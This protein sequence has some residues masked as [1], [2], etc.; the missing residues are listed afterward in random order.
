MPESR[1]EAFNHKSPMG[2]RLMDKSPRWAY[3]MYMWMLTTLPS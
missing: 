2:L 3:A 1:Q